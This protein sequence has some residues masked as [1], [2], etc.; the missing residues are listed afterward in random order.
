M[1]LPIP[2]SV[3]CRRKDGITSTGQRRLEVRVM[4][5]VKATKDSEAGT[6]PSTEGLEVMGMYNECT[7]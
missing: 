1:F 7:V 6:L 5:L 4:V 2:G 3:P